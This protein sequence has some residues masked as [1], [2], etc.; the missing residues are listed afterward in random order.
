MVFFSSCLQ[1][2]KFLKRPAEEDGAEFGDSGAKMPCGVG[3]GNGGSQGS[4]GAARPAE[5]L[6]KFSV[7]IVQQLE[8]T[9][10]TANSQPQ[11]ISTN[12][13]V[14]AL[15]NASVKSMEEPAR[16]APAQPPPPSPVP[17]VECKQEPDSEFVDLEQCAAALEKDAQN[18]NSFP[19]FSELIGNEGSDEIITSDA[20]K[21]LIS[22]ISDFPSEFMK[23]FDFGE[24]A[25]MKVEVDSKEGIVPQQNYQQQYE[26]TRIPPYSG[27]EFGKGEMSPAA[28]TLKQMAE[29]HQH[30]TQLGMGF[31]AGRPS[32]SP[33]TDYQFSQGE[34]K[35]QST[36]T[37]QP[38]VKQEVNFSAS[39]SQSFQAGIRSPGGPKTPTNMM[40]GYKQQYSPYS[41]PGGH[42]SP[43]YM[44]R[45][46]GP[47][48]SPSRPPSASNGPTLQ[49]SQNQQMHINQQSP[50]PQIQVIYL[51]FLFYLDKELWGGISIWNR[52]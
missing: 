14:K 15:T 41:S 10:S 48:P 16:P 46:Q 52:F 32:R 42:S 18:N 43:G 11:Q 28:Q 5:G 31:P 13:T 22:E 21:D 47:G 1:Q 26:K 12:V 27:L 19:G 30:K 34:F 23:D 33:Y 39:Q 20:F 8:F 49:M 17:L 45:G 4:G 9:T 25:M 37:S 35:N 36:N 2:Q 7:E 50:G 51:F 38:E 29:Q 24:N 3:G 6:T 44:P 40:G